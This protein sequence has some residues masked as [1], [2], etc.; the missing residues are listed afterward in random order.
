MLV[1]EANEITGGLSNPSK[2][3]GRA[4]NLS[5]FDCHVGSLL[6]KKEG[7]VCSGCYARKGRYLFSNVKKA[8]AKR[9][10]NLYHPQWVDAMVALINKQSP[11]HFRWHDSGDLQGEKHLRNILEVVRRTPDT[12]HWL[13]TKEYGLIRQYDMRVPSPFRLKNLNIRVSVPMRNQD[14]PSMHLSNMTSSMVVDNVEELR[15]SGVSVC[16]AYT[17]GNVCGDC[18]ACWDRSIQVVAYPSH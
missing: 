16:P 6:A 14:A 9:L 7:S 2:M 17:Q 4:F 3:P 13:P 11:G 1:K 18:R 12:K 5:A 10:A 8:Q 15:G